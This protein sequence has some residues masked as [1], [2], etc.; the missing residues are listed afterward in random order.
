MTLLSARGYEPHVTDQQITLRNC[1][2]H[3]LAVNHTDLV[4]AM[5]LE[6][7][8]GLLGQLSGDPLTARLEPKP[9][10]CCVTIAPSE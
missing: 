7:I 8:D 6:L 2:F 3:E 4:C 5:N 9:G 1:P 10:R